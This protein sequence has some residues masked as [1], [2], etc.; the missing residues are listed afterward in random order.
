M[1]SINDDRQA[2]DDRDRDPQRSEREC[3]TGC[4][5]GKRR[6]RPS[7]GD[8]VGGPDLVSGEIGAKGLGDI[9]AVQLQF[10]AIVADTANEGVVAISAAVDEDIV[11][12]F[13]INKIIAQATLEAIVTDAAIELVIAGATEEVIIAAISDQGVVADPPVDG[14]IATAAVDAVIAL[15]AEETIVPGVP[16]QRVGPNAAKNFVIAR[17]AVDPI[18]ARPAFNPIRVRRAGQNIIQA[19]PNNNGHRSLPHELD[20]IRDEFSG[21]DFRGGLGTGL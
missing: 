9:G 13:A 21:W 4:L 19:G 8:L 3:V 10:Q 1:L 17:P 11:A 5:A 18:V 12:R 7:G 2:F 14:V 20:Q 6:G 15:L 16:C